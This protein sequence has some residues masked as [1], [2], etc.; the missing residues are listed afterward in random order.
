[1]R[2][3]TQLMIVLIYRIY[4]PNQFHSTVQCIINAFN[5][6]LK[7][8]KDLILTSFLADVWYPDNPP[9][10]PEVIR[11]LKVTPE[12]LI[13]NHCSEKGDG[14]VFSLILRRSPERIDRWQWYELQKH[15][16][17]FDLPTVHRYSSVCG[18]CA[19]ISSIYVI[20]NIVIV[21]LLRFL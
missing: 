3:G 6:Q 13:I 2:I 16:Y 12:V 17:S 14:G 20:V 11:I 21:I 15:F 18:G 8:A 7:L 19:V 10:H 1:M 4:C 5:W 9:R